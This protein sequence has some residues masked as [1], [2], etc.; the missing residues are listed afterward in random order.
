M[1]A[2]EDVPLLLGAA[3]VEAALQAAVLPEG[4]L[5]VGAGLSGLLHGLAQQ[6]L[7]AGDL[8]ELHALGLAPVGLGAFVQLVVA[9]LAGVED[10][11]AR[12]FDVA[13]LTQ[14]LQFRW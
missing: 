12:G 10:V 11:A 5:A 9:Q 6:A 14:T 3:V 4:R 2:V 8:L 1:Y 7:H 13:Y